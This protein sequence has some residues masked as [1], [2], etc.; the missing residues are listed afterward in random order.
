MSAFF[1]AS[2]QKATTLN[3]ET[4]TIDLRML[5]GRE[6]ERVACVADALNQDALL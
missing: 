4:M 1:M 5:T 3:Q 6:E 2:W